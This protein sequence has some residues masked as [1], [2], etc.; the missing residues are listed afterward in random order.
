MIEFKQAADYYQSLKPEEK[1]ALAANITESLMF[2]DENII[3]TVLGYFGQVDETLEKI[4][5]QRLYF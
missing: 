3:E 4:L 5:R 1:E 2:E